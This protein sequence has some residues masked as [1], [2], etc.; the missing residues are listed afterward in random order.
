MSKRY[1]STPVV[2]SH[3]LNRNACGAIV[4]DAQ[5]SSNALGETP[6]QRLENAL[7][8]MN[9]RQA[10]YGGMT[11]LQFQAVQ[12]KRKQLWKKKTPASSSAHWDAY[13]ATFSQP[14]TAGK[15]DPNEDPQAKFRRLMGMKGD[16]KPLNQDITHKS[17]EIINKQNKLLADLDQQYEESRF[18]T[19]RARGV[20]FGF[21][22]TVLSSL[23]KTQDVVDEKGP[24]DK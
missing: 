18:L 16:N 24:E 4:G 10:K 14:S 1:P 11:T 23:S 20:G 15:S 19:H 6:E 12:E 21:G 22:G 9:Q 17:S 2:T 7:T 3:T 8:T 13:A 5:G